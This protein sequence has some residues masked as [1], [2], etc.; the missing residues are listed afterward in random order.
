MI[1]VEDL[2]LVYADGTRAVNGVSFN[3]EEGEFFGFLGPNGAGKSTVIK[4]LTTLLRRTSGHVVVAGYDL[5]YD[6]QKIRKVIGVEA[7]ETVIDPDLT[8]KENVI[9][10]GNLQQMRGHNLDERADEL[11]K[12]VGLDSVADKPAGRYS[13]GMK[14]RLQL[15]SSLVHEPKL[16]FLD[17]PTTGLDPQSRLSIWS[18]LEK[19]NKE[20]GVTIFLTT[21]YLEEADRLCERLAIIDAGNIIATGTPAELKKQIGAD[22]ITLA[23]EAADH[24]DDARARA[25]TIVGGIEGIT[26]VQDSDSGLTAHAK[27]ASQIIAS[28]VRALDENHI[29]LTSVSFSSPTLDDVFMYHTGRR[30]RAEEL[31]RMPEHMRGFGRRRF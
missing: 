30:I 11:L 28:L 18:Y 29:K 22:T 14:K 15:A 20:Q 25:K 19:L 9:L 13:G 7:Q 8:G 21:Q 31:G 10:Q 5:A 27:N 24:P 2:V 26:D 23:V 6:A 16:L 12:L 4:V 3:V 1:E 17:E